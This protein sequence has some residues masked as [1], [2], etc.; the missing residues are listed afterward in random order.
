MPQPSDRERL[1]HI[2][3]AVDWIIEFTAAIDFAAFRADRKTQL[4]VERSLEIIGEAANHI[5]GELTAQYAAVPWRKIVDMRNIVSHEYFQVRQE[6]LWQ[7][8]TDD[9]PELRNRIAGILDELR[10]S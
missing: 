8:V 5:S 4:S 1:V 2:L 10:D 3:E 7:V 9:V 6:V